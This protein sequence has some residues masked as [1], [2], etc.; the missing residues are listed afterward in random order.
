MTEIPISWNKRGDLRAF[1]LLLKLFPADF[2]EEYE[3]CMVQI[4]RDQINDAATRR[5]YIALWLRVVFDIIKNAI[6][7]RVNLFAIENHPALADVFW[8][9]GFSVSL[10]FPFHIWDLYVH[11]ML[12]PLENTPIGNFL[13]LPIMQYAVIGFLVGLFQW[14]FIRKYIR[15]NLAWP[16]ITCIAW[17][18]GGLIGGGLS[19]ILFA[20]LQELQISGHLI[21]AS[22][23]NL[24]TFG[25]NYIFIFSSAFLISISQ[26]FFLPKSRFRWLWI[27]VNMIAWLVQ[28]QIII[29]LNR[30]FYR[31]EPYYYDF[32]NGLGAIAAGLI[33]G[34]FLRL[35]I[36]YVDLEKKS[37][38]S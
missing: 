32:R 29:Y 28:Y 26:L 24:L 17:S 8:I 13:W 1:R 11:Q 19:N 27:M 9:L 10:V 5:E 18:L 21:T 2:L 20:D 3:Y 7:E 4:F 23:R 33:M 22:Q 35:L 31:I 34:I 37:K 14:V 30:T 16:F 12:G 15:I 38:L 36:V 25:P 6:Q